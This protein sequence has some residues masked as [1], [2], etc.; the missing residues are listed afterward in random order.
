MPSF[1]RRA[2][3]L[4]GLLTGA[5]A[6]AAALLY[7][8]PADGERSRYGFEFELLQAA[9]N[10][11]HKAGLASGPGVEAD[12]VTWSAQ[13]MTPSRARIEL[14]AGKLSVIHSYASPDLDQRLTPVPFSLD[15]GLSSQRILLTRRDL[16]PRLAA[17]RNADD[18]K[19]MRFGV[20]G[21][22]SDRSLLRAHGFKTEA[23][24][25]FGGLFKMLA[26]ERS[27]VIM[28]GLLHVQ[29]VNPY[30]AEF[31]ELTWEPTLLIK[32]PSELRY[33]TTRSQTGEALAKRLLR[34]LQILQASGELERLQTRHFGAQMSATAGRRLI[35]LSK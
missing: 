28:T 33:Y 3:L 19:A 23:T 7:P 4:A 34:G 15:K 10:A 2:L 8:Q 30:L 12:T 9:L 29:Q 31:S 32:L 16:L 25:S 27:D 6:Q 20:L 18:L 22:W 21:S 35:D 24:E 11:D 17:V 5:A 26:L 1:F 13:T 14:A